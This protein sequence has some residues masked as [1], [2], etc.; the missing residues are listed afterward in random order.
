[1]F[2]IIG[3]AVMQSFGRYADNIKGNPVKVGLVERAEDREWASARCGRME[4]AKTDTSRKK[5]K[6]RGN[7]QKSGTCRNGLVS[8]DAPG[9]AA[10]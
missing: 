10:A 8:F 1:M 9:I 2:L 7:G 4:R 5:R 6:S 3:F